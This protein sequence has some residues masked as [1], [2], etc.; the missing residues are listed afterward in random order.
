MKVERWLQTSELNQQLY[1]PQD[2]AAYDITI[3][4]KKQM[5]ADNILTIRWTKQTIYE[6]F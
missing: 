6:I 5:N 1:V 4:R 2:Y 3:V